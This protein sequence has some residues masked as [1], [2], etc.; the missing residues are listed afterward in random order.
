MSSRGVQLYLADILEAIEKIGRYTQGISFQDFTKDGKTVDA[1]LRNLA[2]IG[3]AAARIPEDFAS[4]VRKCPGR[5]SSACG[6]RSS[7]NTSGW[8]KR[9]SGKTVTEDLGGLRLRSGLAGP[10]RSHA[11]AP[12]PPSS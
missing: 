12:P 1:V 3:E 6:I 5:R 8:T 10:R 11:E 9:F 2:V 7:T 4:R